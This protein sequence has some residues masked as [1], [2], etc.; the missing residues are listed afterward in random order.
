M[1]CLSREDENTPLLS[2]FPDFLSFMEMGYTESL[3][4]YL[5][6]LEYHV[7]SE[8]A[9]KTE[10]THLLWTK[11]VKVFV[12]Q[13]WDGIKA[14]PLH[15]NFIEGMPAAMKPKARP[16]NPKLFEH[17]KREFD[18][19]ISYIYVRCDGP[20]ASPLV[21]RLLHLSFGSVVI[22]RVSTSLYCIGILLSR[23][24][25]EQFPRSWRIM[26]LLHWIYASSTM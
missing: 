17:A 19:L 26:R 9:K 18:R 20:V 5:D 8:Y 4:A 3:Q 23:I 14:K 7:H 12:S 11:G 2:S 13:N 25:N 21:I 15:I 10:I 16:V 22:M 24:H 6:V 1:D